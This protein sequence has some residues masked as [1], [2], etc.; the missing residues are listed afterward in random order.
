MSL[1]SFQRHGVF[2]DRSLQK[3]VAKRL[4]SAKAI[5]AARAMPYQLLMAY[6]KT[7]G[8]VPTRISEALQDAMDMAIRNVPRLSENCHGNRCVRFD[9]LAAQW[10]TRRRNIFG[11][12]SSCGGVM[13][14]GIA[15]TEPKFIGIAVS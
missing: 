13:C 4:K 6:E 3:L 5:S 1:A 14:C 7:V 2:E 11:H 15:A 12:L 9:A 10:S 8:V